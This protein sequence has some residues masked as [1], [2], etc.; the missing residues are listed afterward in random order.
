[1]LWTD[2]TCRIQIEGGGFNTPAAVHAQLCTLESEWNK[3]R[4][5]YLD[6]EDLYPQDRNAV[7]A[8]GQWLPP[9]ERQTIYLAG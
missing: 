1:M 6:V 9:T 8:E 2:S 7:E 4:E 3:V 5:K